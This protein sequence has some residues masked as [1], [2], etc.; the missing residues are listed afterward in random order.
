M[1]YQTNRILSL[2]FN[3]LIAAFCLVSPVW[4]SDAVDARDRLASAIELA[5]GYGMA[6]AITTACGPPGQ[7]DRIK[8]VTDALTT[9]V[10]E[11][12]YQDDQSV[13][14]EIELAARK[15]M[16]VLGGQLLGRQLLG[17]CPE[18]EL[19]SRSRDILQ[20]MEQRFDV[21]PPTH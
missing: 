17:Y 15:T 4:A 3:S 21:T 11:I 7:P 19:V 8:P 16:A 1:I 9:W 14:L 13:P 6:V 5:E 18:D 10:R 12:G 20:R 2:L